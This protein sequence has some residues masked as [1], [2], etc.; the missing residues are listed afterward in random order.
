MTPEDLDYV[1]CSFCG[2]TLPREATKDGE[3]I[4][5]QWCAT[6]ASAAI[7]ESAQVLEQ[8][9]LAVEAEREACALIADVT[10]VTAAMAIRGRR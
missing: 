4:D 3:C 9:R 1:K 2:V 6:Q 8:V 5:R 10:S 7:S